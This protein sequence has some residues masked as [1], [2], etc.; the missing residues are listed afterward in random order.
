MG[1]IVRAWEEGAPEMMAALPHSQGESM[2]LLL[3]K[4]ISGL[5][6]VFGATWIAGANANADTAKRGNMLANARNW[7]WITT[8]VR[9]ERWQR[10]TE[11]AER[12][13]RW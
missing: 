5:T 12:G 11:S 7:A 4:E 2:A 3:E 10:K 9:P 6:F 8:I 13:G 1:L